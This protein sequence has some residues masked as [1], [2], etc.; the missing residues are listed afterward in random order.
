M[1]VREIFEGNDPLLKRDYS[2][3]IGRFAYSRMYNKGETVEDRAI[4]TIV[5]IYYYTPDKISS[6]QIGWVIR[7]AT[8]FRIEYPITSTQSAVSSTN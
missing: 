1:N 5:D 7:Y 4:K 3:I 8:K 2:Y 6:K